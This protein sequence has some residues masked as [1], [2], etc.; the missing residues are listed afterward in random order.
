MSALRTSMS[1]K[2]SFKVATTKQDYILAMPLIQELNHGLTEE[3]FWQYQKEMTSLGNYWLVLA[4]EDHDL[5]GICGYW[6]A[7]KFYTGKYMEIDNFIIDS[8]HRSKRY[9]A[10]FINYL[11]S[12]AMDQ[13]CE[14]VML[15]AYL[16][17]TK[18][19]E[20]YKRHTYLPCGYHFIKK[21][22]DNPS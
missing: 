19:H 13:E 17:N 5:I 4:F 12:I 7:T 14:T 6:I 21:I 20:F 1:S 11:E 18:G 10:Y 9:G 2:L 8:K 3:A 22:G 15:D 16:E